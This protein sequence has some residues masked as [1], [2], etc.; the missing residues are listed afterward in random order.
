MSLRLSESNDTVAI[1]H[2]HQSIYQERVL[3][4]LALYLSGLF[5]VAAN[6]LS[7]KLFQCRDCV[8]VAGIHIFALIT[9]EV[10]SVGLYR[11]DEITLANK[12]CDDHR[13]K[14]QESDHGA[15]SPLTKLFE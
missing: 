11:F 10:L 6:N 1:A 12:A 8:V 3:L 7:A 14:D 4:D 5:R 9:N 2:W 15:A 13:E